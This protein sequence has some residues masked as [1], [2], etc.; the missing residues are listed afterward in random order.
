M[1]DSLTVTMN[2]LASKIIELLLYILIVFVIG[3][4]IARLTNNQ[5]LARI[6]SVVAMIAALFLWV[7]TLT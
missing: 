4:V 5:T 2:G 7:K 1:F 6:F 3:I